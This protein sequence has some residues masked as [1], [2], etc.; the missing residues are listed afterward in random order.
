[1]AKPEGVRVL[2]VSKQVLEALS[3]HIQAR[4]DLLLESGSISLTRVRMSKDLKLAKVGVRCLF[5]DASKGT[6]SEQELK[7]HQKAVD[8][9]QERHH[10]MQR[11]LSKE[12]QLR[13]TPKLQFVVDESWDEILKVENTL[14]TLNVNPAPRREDSTSNGDET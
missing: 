8:L 2:Q 1:M 5:W 6:T 10:E 7:L 14:R 13:F 11:Y 12:L 9:L 3:R 4:S